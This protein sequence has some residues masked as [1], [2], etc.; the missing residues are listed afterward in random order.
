MGRGAGGGLRRRVAMGDELRDKD[1][2]GGGFY[3]TLHKLFD[4]IVL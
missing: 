4:F 1:F 3:S 2:F